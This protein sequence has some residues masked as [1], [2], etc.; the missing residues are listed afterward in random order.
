M[1]QTIGADD[2]R[3]WRADVCTFAE[4]VLWCERPDTGRIEPLRLYPEQREWL[5]AATECDDEGHFVRRLCVAS[6]PKRCGKSAV[7]AVLATWRALLRPGER[8]VVLANSEKQAASNVYDLIACYFR[9]S[10]ALQDLADIGRTRL[11]I[12]D[13]DAVV[14]C[15]PCN[16]RTVQGR[17]IDCLCSDELH[18]AESTE[19]F[20]YASMQTESADAQ[21]L[22]SSQA[23]AP[24][25]SN[26][27]WRLW[28]EGQPE[29]HVLFDYRTA[30][31]TPWAIDRAEQ[32]REELLGGEWDYLWGNQWGATGLKL[33]AAGDIERALSWDYTEPRTRADW[34]AL[35]LTWGWDPAA[36]TLAVGLDRAGVARTGD[37]T[38]WTVV[39]EH[40]GEAAVLW[41]TVLPTGSEAEILEA[42]ADTIAVF[43]YPT[44]KH[45]EFYNCGD[46]VGKLQG[47]QL[48]TPTPGAQQQWFSSLA[49]RF[50]AGRIR[51][52][53]SAGEHKDARG[54]WTRD[55]FKAEL[56]A[57]EY[58]AERQRGATVTRFGTQAGNDD[59]CYS[60]AIAHDAL[61]AAPIG[62]GIA[63]GG[64]H[65]A[66][67]RRQ[68]DAE[69][70]EMNP[71]RQIL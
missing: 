13:T 49:R 27:L 68:Q 21:V 34:L 30:P 9:D 45:L 1:M 23:G 51:I 59:T 18:A 70:E 17:R 15:V 53:R 5:R 71:W 42:D 48:V 28:R 35:C 8:I 56:L 32:A 63:T 40:G 43:G 46:I 3:R 25:G 10:P 61:P 26:P 47:A 44:R 4:E 54:R 50:V 7:V 22:V 20:V 60:L 36:V 19:P 55:I 64:S 67:T 39:G 37:R 2:L 65:R 66:A 57:F 31:F 14:E 11:T 29:S 33:F 52:P 12:T 24:V 6:W 69:Q 16:H 38:V 41:S 62:L 58:D